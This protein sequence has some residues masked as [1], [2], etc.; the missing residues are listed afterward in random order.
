MLG[1]GR[2]F[3]IEIKDPK[4]PFPEP[5]ELLK[6][7]EQINSHANGKVQVQDLTLIDK[8]QVRVM[9]DSISSKSKTY[10]YSLSLHTI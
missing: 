3:Y 10:S 2:P 1:T 5:N 9:T 4:V 6:I 7:Q 8:E